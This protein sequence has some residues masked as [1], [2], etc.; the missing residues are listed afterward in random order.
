[1]SANFSLR[2]KV[3]VVTGGT[4]I[5]GG[6]FVQAIAAA[7]GI[8]VILGRNSAIARQRAD[9][10]IQQGGIALAVNA[11]VLDMQQLTAA[12]DII[13]SKLGTIHGLVNAAGG[14]LP[15]GV[16]SPSADVFDL[17]LSGMKAAMDLNIWGTIFPT[18]VF[19]QVM[20]QQQ[21]GSIVNISSVTSQLAVTRVLGYS[22]GK[23]AVDC[24]TKWMA[25]EV[26]NRFGDKIRVNS[27]IPGF[28]IT[29]QNKQLLTQPDGTY[30]ERGNKVIQHTPFKRFGQPEELNGAIIYL[31]SDA[32][33]FVNG[34]EIKVDGAFT[35]FSGV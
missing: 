10:I 11:D 34:S 35:S 30:T 1:M 31:L 20:A 22:M 5:L 32:S 26:A 14:N 12:K 21:G 18:Q 29:E 8:P 25:V 9:Q 24:F 23:A 33:G 6:T 7:G 17:N 2:D 3:I 15:E 4:G 27:I 13:V 19:G 16:L 28:F